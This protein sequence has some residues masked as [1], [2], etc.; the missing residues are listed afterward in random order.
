[1]TTLQTKKK[2][3]HQY[4]DLEKLTEGNKTVIPKAYRAKT[5]LVP[6]HCLSNRAGNLA[7]SQELKAK[8]QRI[9]GVKSW[10]LKKVPM[11]KAESQKL[12]FSSAFGFLPI[13]L[14]F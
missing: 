2:F 11:I 3:L 10:K 4:I 5:E 12:Y 9:S 1:V 13:F 14:V 6:F 7:N 8:S